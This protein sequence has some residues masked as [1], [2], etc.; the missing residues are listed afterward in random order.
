MHIL[1]HGF[2]VE[3]ANRLL[4][5]FGQLNRHHLFDACRDGERV[6]SAF[7]VND[8]NALATTATAT[9]ATT[10]R[11]TTTTAATTATE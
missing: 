1:K 6:E 10:A 9:T 2:A 4:F 8:N 3:Q 5:V 11:T 7:G